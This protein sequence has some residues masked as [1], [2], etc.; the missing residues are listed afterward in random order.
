[1]ISKPVTA[2]MMVLPGDVILGIL[3]LSHASQSSRSMALVS[4][5]DDGGPSEIL[6]LSNQ[7][8]INTIFSTEV[9]SFSDILQ[10]GSSAN[11]FFI[12]KTVPRKISLGSMPAMR[13]ESLLEEG[14]YVAFWGYELHP[15]VAKNCWPL[16]LVN[17]LGEEAGEF[18]II[19][20]IK[21]DGMYDLIYRMRSKGRRA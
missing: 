10:E 12:F 4:T 13:E 11:R 5:M 9:N 15:V 16:K 6:V 1:M 17:R 2:N 21:E 19:D 3:H 7:S 20:V 18:Q 14:G 8:K